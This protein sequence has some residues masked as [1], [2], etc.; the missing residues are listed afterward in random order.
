MLLYI[1]CA[2]CG[3]RH[4]TP[5]VSPGELAEIDRLFAAADATDASSDSALRVAI[6]NASAVSAEDKKCEYTFTHG[7][8]ESFAER[9]ARWDPEARRPFQAADVALIY[10][11]SQLEVLLTNEVRHEEEQRL[12]A[13]VDVDGAELVEQA[14][15]LV[16]G[17]AEIQLVLRIAT[18][19]DAKE[20]DSERFSAGAA[21]GRA[22]LYDGASRRIVCAG[23]F[24]ATSSRAINVFVDN[25]PN[26][27]PHT[28]ELQADLFLNLLD[29]A[30]QG[31]RRAR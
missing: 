26:P 30:E 13:R 11:D 3:S 24:H 2:A 18:I 12:R 15:A 4:R 17:P 14:K 23:D 22:Y 27:K 6:T 29:S 28:G 21:V 8:G 31:L 1:A 7:D 10:D 25:K 19:Q 5:Y 9:I 16:A 20:L